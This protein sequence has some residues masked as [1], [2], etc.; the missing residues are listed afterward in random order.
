MPSAKSKKK[1]AK[2]EYVSVFDVFPWLRSGLYDHKRDSKEAVEKAR[3][4]REKMEKAHPKAKANAWGYKWH[5]C[6]G[7]PRDGII[8]VDPIYFIDSADLD[9]AQR[10]A[11]E[12]WLDGQT[13][14]LIPGV[15]AASWTHDYERFYDSYVQG[16]IATII[17]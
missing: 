17:D 16:R 8:M 1:P 3:K 6:S 11:Y 10:K 14:P 15:E 2:T 7:H 12:K 4:K 5:R 9:K 13:R